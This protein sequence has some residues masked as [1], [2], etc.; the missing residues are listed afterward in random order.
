MSDHHT[1]ILLTKGI[2]KR[3]IKH[4]GVY[5]RCAELFGEDLDKSQLLIIECAEQCIVAGAFKGWDKK[6]VS[7]ILNYKKAYKE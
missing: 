3:L 1:K 4:G 6:L 2:I 7:D 5:G